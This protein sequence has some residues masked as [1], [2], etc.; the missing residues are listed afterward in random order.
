ME[1]ERPLWVGF[2]SCSIIEPLADLR[3]L[4]LLPNPK[5]ALT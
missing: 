3:G 1:Q 2:G 4:G 5:E